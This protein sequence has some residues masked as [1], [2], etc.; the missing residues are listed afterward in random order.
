[1]DRVVLRFQRLRPWWLEGIVL[2][3][4]CRLA[5]PVLQCAS[6][7]ADPICLPGTKPLAEAE[8]LAGRMLAGV[9]RW[10]DQSLTNSVE[11]RARYW[12]RECTSRTA[13]ERSVEGNRERFRKRIGLVD[14]REAVRDFEM[15]GTVGRS[16]KVGE[17]GLYWIYTV[18]WPV[19]EDVHGEGL[20]LYPKGA[21][22]AQVV[23][24]PDADQ[25]PEM[26]VGLA[27]GVDAKS[28]YARRLAEN[29]CLVVVPVLVDRKDTWSGNAQLKQ[30]TNLPHREWIFRQAQ[31]VGRHI[32]G[33]E[34]QKVLAAVDWFEGVQGPRLAAGTSGRPPGRPPKIG[35]VGYGE[36][37]L[38]ALY[39][40]AADKRI[41]AALVSGY[42]QA[43]PAPWEEPVYR[44]VF[45][46][47]E[48]FGDAEIGSLIVPRLLVVE[49][50]QVPRVS[51]APPEREGRSGADS[52][53]LVTPDQWTVER[54]V[55]RLRQS[56]PPDGVIRPVVRL[57]NGS[58]GLPVIPGSE[59]ALMDFLGAFTEKVVPLAPLR[60]APAATQATVDPLERQ[61]RQVRE[62]EA[63]AQRLVL[64]AERARNTFVWS[65]LAQK[66]S[67]ETR[68]GLRRLFRDEVLGRLP[69]ATVS[70]NPRSRRIQEVPGWRGYEVVLDLWPE[71]FV[72]GTLLLPKNLGSNERRPAVVCAPAAGNAPADGQPPAPASVRRVGAMAANLAERGFVVFVPA[73]RVGPDEAWRKV[74]RKA[75][76]LGAS[77]QAL[78]LAQQERS[79]EWLAAQ[80]FVD[81]ARLGFCGSA[82]SG[83]MDLIVPALLDKYAAVVC[84]ADFGDWA[85][86]LGA[87]GESESW[88]YR[89]GWDLA[90][91]NLANKWSAAE[92]AGLVAPRPFRVA[93]R[94][95]KETTEDE[96]AGYMHA[97]V[98]GW[99]ARLG[100]PER[101]EIEFDDGTTPGT[102]AGTLRFLH[103][104]LGWA[105]PSP[106]K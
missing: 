35:V 101:T 31:T 30:F 78:F 92:L 36:G 33:Y 7:A 68:V 69:P 4:L 59:L 88:L 97:K 64:Q 105:E 96:W 37:G 10:F 80:P 61:E 6:W 13:Y 11:G 43:R 24:L 79:V 86:Q 104:Q 26:L 67:E 77:I 102:D 84:R 46:L 12:R 16:A 63:H 75:M 53:G 20:L 70:A 87:V 41:E 23:A 8:D 50:S 2:L 91:L 21:V 74:Q 17:T 52:G 55:I 65:P 58:E 51:G 93:Q 90:V 14:E 9:D 62:L 18:R 57:I 56:F 89:A 32:I 71:V 34:V 28:Q 73:G 39:A 100:K 66:P 47:L 48:E 72:W 15:V 29:G 40:A 49:H 60:E 85:R 3:V 5:W 81:P 22:T 94:C 19:L 42:F 103:K 99:Y 83:A 54:E 25:T 82:E 106:P 38:I 1:M 95:G 98:H 44:S 76:P 45:G 27:P